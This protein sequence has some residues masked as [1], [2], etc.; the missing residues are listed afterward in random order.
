[1][2]ITKIVATRGQ[3][4]RPKCTKSNSISAGGR[5]EGK[6]HG[7]PPPSEILNTPLHGREFDIGDGNGID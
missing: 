7:L 5:G 4:L 6:G 3:I 2:K 1:M